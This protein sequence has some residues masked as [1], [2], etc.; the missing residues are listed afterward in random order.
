M[1]MPIQRVAEEFNNL[2]E[3]IKRYWKGE[4]DSENTQKKP[5]RNRW[6]LYLILGLGGLSVASLA[7]YLLVIRRRQ[8]TVSNKKPRSHYIGELIEKPIEKTRENI[9]ID[10]LEPYLSDTTSYYQ[11]MVRANQEKRER[12]TFDPQWRISPS[13]PVEQLTNSQSKKKKKNSINFPTGNGFVQYRSQTLVGREAGLPRI[14]TNSSGLANDVELDSLI[15]GGNSNN[16]T[17]WIY[18]LERIRYV[19][20]VLFYRLPRAVA[21]WELWLGACSAA[22]YFIAMNQPFG[23]GGNK[24]K[25][26]KKVNVGD[27]MFMDGV[28]HRVVQSSESE[29]QNGVSKQVVKVVGE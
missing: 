5:N 15:V 21:E 12:V 10:K 3:E 28:M 23:F 8:A 26:G 9:W 25:S 22:I 14:F 16:Q 24:K 17:R 13:Y 7:T 1:M 2:V 20:S 4:D 27:S 6:L 19:I 18:Y 29:Q 11:Y